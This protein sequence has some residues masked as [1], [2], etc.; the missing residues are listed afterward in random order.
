MKLQ[1]II[2]LIQTAEIVKNSGKEKKKFVLGHIK[3]ENIEFVSEII[4]FIV[5]LDK[6]KPGKIIK[7]NIYKCCILW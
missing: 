3:D 1:T 2:E 7:K 5:F 6:S 4:D